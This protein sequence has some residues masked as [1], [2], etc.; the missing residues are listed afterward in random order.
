MRDM[1]RRA[2]VTAIAVGCLA[3]AGVTGAS[4]AEAASARSSGAARLVPGAYIY[5]Y[6]QLYLD[7]EVAGA[8]GLYQGW[9]RNYICD[10]RYIPGYFALVI[11]S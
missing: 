4:T 5:G 8:Y 10:N 3:G 11:V 2:F 9:W 6:Y 7:C 1:I